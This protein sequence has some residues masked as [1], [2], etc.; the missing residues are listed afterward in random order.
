MH[1]RVNY[2]IVGLFVVVLGVALLAAGLWLAGD[3]TRDDGNRFLVKPTEP[4][5]GLGTNS[6]VK[7]QGIDV[8][9]VRELGIDSQGNVRVLIS[10]DP[11]VPVRANTRVRLGSQGLTGLGHLE[12][13]PGSADAGPAL[14]DEYAYPVLPN[15]P[16]LRT[17]LETA[18]EDGLA[19]IDRVGRQLEV[20][21]SDDN[22]RTLQSTMDHVETI[23]G[24]LAANSEQLTATLAETEALLRDTRAVL[25]G[26]P[27][28]M[29]RIDRTLETFDETARRFGDTAERLGDT[30]ERGELALQRLDR[31]TLP[32]LNQLLL[33]VQGLTGT[34]ERL[35][36]EL[37]EHPNRLIFGAP[38]RPPGPGESD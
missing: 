21:L 7:Y 28:T 23:S 15:A 12:L 26:A 37:T 32:Q 30:G 2:T 25:S 19:S 29:A 36:T 6:T 33:D 31:E 14:A 35:G 1:N 20:L 24:T 13:V 5:T 4:M 18:V 8:G 38:R 3:F 27:E 34:Y 22:L 10:V 11:D 17:R 16:S 9:R